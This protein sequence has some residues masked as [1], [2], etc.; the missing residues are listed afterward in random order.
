[1]VEIAAGADL[2]APSSPNIRPKQTHTEKAA[3]SPS[4][5]QYTAGLEMFAGTKGA[6]IPDTLAG[7]CR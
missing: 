3:D 5:G 6:T 2:A 7:Y 4:R 1:M